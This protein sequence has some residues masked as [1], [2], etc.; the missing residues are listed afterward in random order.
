M[1]ATNQA[2]GYGSQIVLADGA[3]PAALDCSVGN[4]FTTTLGGN[5]TIPQFLNPIPGAT[6]RY[7]LK[8]DGTG[9][10]TV[11]WPSNVAWPAATAPT[12]TT[13]ANKY[14]ILVFVYNEVAGTWTGSSQLNFT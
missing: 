5:R 12:L 8:Q 14:D 4:A 3:P 11:T 10:R 1:A 13:T 7:Y 6:V 2:F 9:S